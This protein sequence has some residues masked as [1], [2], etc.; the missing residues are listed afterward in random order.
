MESVRGFPL[1]SGFT[2]QRTRTIEGYYD[3]YRYD[4]DGKLISIPS[5]TIEGEE[6]DKALRIPKYHVVEQDGYIW[7]WMG[8]DKPV[9]EP[10]EV[11]SVG[12]YVWNQQTQWIEADPTL[13]LQHEMDWPSSLSQDR[14]FWAHRR[15]IIPL[16][17]SM[18]LEQPYE[19]RV[20]EKG[21]EIFQPPTS[22][23]SDSKIRQARSSAFSLP[24]R[25]VHQKLL[26]RAFWRGFGDFM[27]IAHFIPEIDPLTG[28]II[29]RA[30]YMWTPLLLPGYAFQRNKITT[31]SRHIPGAL[32][33]YRKEDK[34]V[35]E[36][37]QANI[38]H[39]A[40]VET[41][42]VSPSYVDIDAKPQEASEVPKDEAAVATT[43]SP[44]SH[45]ISQA[46]TVIGATPAFGTEVAVDSP[47]SA[48]RNILQLGASDTWTPENANVIIPGGRHVGS[49]RVTH[50][51]S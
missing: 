51:D 10:M 23:A 1:S 20:T 38:N 42:Q 5:I 21:F 40:A 22:S 17:K 33:S 14:L 27:S 47:A 43:P 3:K 37:L 19:T 32:P 29:T 31:L 7:V 28:K 8:K 15:S 26:K 46:M 49:F 16:R 18:T 44:I 9:G 36:T 2:N 12:E 25:V 34:I 41:L 30:E 6:F 50:I 13:C 24:D 11:P 48:V 35:L 4:S 39:W 45:T